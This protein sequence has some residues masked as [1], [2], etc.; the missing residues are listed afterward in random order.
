DDPLRTVTGTPYMGLVVPSNGNGH[1]H[2]AI[3]RVGGQAPAPKDVEAP[4]GTITAHDRQMALIV[5]NMQH[6]AG[7]AVSEPTPT[8]TTGG[9]H[10]LVQAAHGGDSRPP[11]HVDEPMPTVAGHGECGIVALR[12]HDTARS[13]SEPTGTVVGGGFHHGLLIYNGMPG[14]VR[15]LEDA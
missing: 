8:V 9:N 14:F 4:M 6:N 11:R 10:M 13:I 1:H 15:E 12:N 5:Q 3:V 2:G 7:R